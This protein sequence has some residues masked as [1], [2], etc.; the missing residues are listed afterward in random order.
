MQ[1]DRQ[2]YCASIGYPSSSILKTLSQ[3]GQMISFMSL[4]LLTP[5][6]WALKLNFIDMNCILLSKFTQ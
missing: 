6:F 3:C 5:L 2:P 4:S 1:E